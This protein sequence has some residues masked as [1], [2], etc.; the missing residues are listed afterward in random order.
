MSVYEAN[1]DDD[2]SND[3]SVPT[4][5]SAS[6]LEQTRST[7]SVGDKDSAVNGDS[8]SVTNVTFV[9]ADESSDPADGDEVGAAKFKYM[10][11]ADV[12]EALQSG[13]GGDGGVFRVK[14]IDSEDE[15]TDHETLPATN[16]RNNTSSSPPHSKAAL[17]AADVLSDS[18]ADV[19][20]PSPEMKSDVVQKQEQNSEVEKKSGESPKSSPVPQLNVVASEHRREAAPGTVAA[21]V[22]N[23]AVQVADESTAD[24]KKAPPQRNVVRRRPSQQQSAVEQTKIAAVFEL[25]ID[26]DFKP[27]VFSDVDLD[28]LAA[29][30]GSAVEKLKQFL[31]NDQCSSQHIP[32]AVQPG[33]AFDSLKYFLS[34]LD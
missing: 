8:A 11:A 32:T 34:T 27:T 6:D 9:T 5:N 20:P 10:N 22:K 23:P 14:S 16:S 15:E 7:P 18:T 17:P 21:V 30:S 13:G 28:H 12:A 2:A 4:P 31:E 1:S 19:I 25:H 3:V 29:G 33:K 24:G 26:T